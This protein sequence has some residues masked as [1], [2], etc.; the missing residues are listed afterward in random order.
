M[1]VKDLIKFF[2]I[3]IY[4]LRKSRCAEYDAKRKIIEYYSI[5]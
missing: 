4:K 1:R 2:I 5:A 3:M